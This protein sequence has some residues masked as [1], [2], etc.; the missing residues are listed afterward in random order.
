MGVHIIIKNKKQIVIVVLIVVC[1]LGGFGIQQL[2]KKVK[3]VAEINYT[4]DKTMVDQIK[5]MRENKDDSKP[6]YEVYQDLPIIDVH[7]H[8]VMYL[9]MTETR[10]GDR[11]TSTKVI[12]EKYGIDKTVLFGDVSE[13]SAIRT[14]KLSWKYYNKY[15]DLIYPSFAGVPLKEDQN[16]IEIVTERLEQGYLNIGEIYAASTYSPSADVIWKAE[17]PNWGVLPD[18]YDLAAKY[19]V[20][21]LLHIDPPNGTPIAYLKKAMK[22]HPDTIFV[23]AHGN[24]YNKPENLKALLKEYDNLYV[25]FFPGFTRYNSGSEHKL[26][27]FV[28]VIEEYPD[29]FFLGSDSGIEIGLE[30]SY[31]AM[32]ELLD[33]LSPKT[34][35]KVAYQ[36]YEKLIEQQP[37]T[38]SQIKKIKELSKELNITSKTYQLNK[39]EANEQIFQL[40][41]NLR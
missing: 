9:D 11:N 33:L 31:K 10:G 18:I 32:Y 26:A 17:H 38:D 2:N 6:L 21:V 4:Y 24:V 19:E 7:N 1:V 25:D 39:R 20:P 23:F 36:N 41:E 22:N 34:A 8:D 28:S 14:D 15:P 13:P 30:N 3:V 35:A 37:P 27:D 16:G 40:E 5:K 29:R 12:W